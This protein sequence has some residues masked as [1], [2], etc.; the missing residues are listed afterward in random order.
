[1]LYSEGL[2]KGINFLRG[3]NRPR[4]LLASCGP[5]GTLLTHYNLI[6]KNIYLFF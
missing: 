4:H 1:M 6:L 2:K 3:R 5:K